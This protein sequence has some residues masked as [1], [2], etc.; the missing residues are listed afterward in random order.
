M[1]ASSIENKALRGDKGQ[2]QKPERQE[3]F[4]GWGGGGGA[5]TVSEAFS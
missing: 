2:Q 5:E 3:E 1:L 4:L